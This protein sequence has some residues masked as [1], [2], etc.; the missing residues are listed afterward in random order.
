MVQKII[1][2]KT[3]DKTFNDIATFLEQ[4]ASLS[5]AEKFAEKVDCKIEK[6]TKQPFIGRPSSKA[7][8][9]RKILISKHIQM[10]Y[11]VVGKTL[12]VSTFFDSR[13]HPNKSRF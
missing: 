3:A 8:T 9:V 1:F 2:T 11:R 13:Q 7:K 10:F 4:N 12:I 6:L 5:S